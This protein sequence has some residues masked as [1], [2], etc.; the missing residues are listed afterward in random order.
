MDKNVSL[1]GKSVVPAE[2]LSLLSV[3][4]QFGSFGAFPA[5]VDLVSTFVDLNIQ[6]SLYR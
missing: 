1:R 6:G 2:Y 4:G 5:F 3:Q